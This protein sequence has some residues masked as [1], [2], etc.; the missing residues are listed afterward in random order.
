MYGPALNHTAAILTGT[1]GSTSLN[2]HS[3]DTVVPIVGT[4]VCNSGI[5]TQV[6]SCGTIQSGLTNITLQYLNLWSG[7]YSFQ[8]VMDEVETF[9]TLMSGDSGTGI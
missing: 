5:T 1:N 3:F 8:T 9:T 4:I 6:A 2:V 7:L